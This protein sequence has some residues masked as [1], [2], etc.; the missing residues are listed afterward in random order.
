[1]MCAWKELISIL[2]IR[3]RD[4]V[5]RLGKDTMQ[6]LRLR[7][8]AQ[9]EIVLR[10]E[11]LWLNVAVTRD[12]L[13][14]VINAASQYSPWCA[15]TMAQGYITAAGGHRIGLCGTTICR[16]GSMVGMREVDSICIR[17]A[18]D[19]PGIGERFQTAEDSI[20]IIGAPG[21]GKTTMLRD[22]IRQISL[23]ETVSVVD[24]RGELFP[25][26]FQRGKRT[27]VLLGCPK[28][29]GIDLVLRTMGPCCIAVDE[30]TE[31]TDCSALI[32][33]ANCGVRLLAT[34]HANSMR[35]FLRRAVYKPL[36]K[37]QIFRTIIVLDKEK[38]FRV[39]RM[40]V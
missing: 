32:Q 9:P 4:E 25:I 1:M 8:Y 19:F 17:V 31:E 20:L 15:E 27:D 7:I 13:N 6:E 35:D 33:A 3:L 29:I 14:F 21:W 36:I 26:G 22:V 40:T 39:E 5:D 10:E 12:D 38:S 11:S 2:P 18:R 16:D 37:K 23:Y 34:A 28:R 24:E 30:I